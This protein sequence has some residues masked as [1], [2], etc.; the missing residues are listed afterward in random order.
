MNGPR[1]QPNVRTNA[2]GVKIFKPVAISISRPRRPRW[3]ATGAW[4]WHKPTAAR[5]AWRGNVPSPRGD[6]NVGRRAADGGVSCVDKLLRAPAR[7]LT[8]LIVGV[9]FVGN[10]PAGFVRWPRRK[11]P[12]RPPPKNLAPFRPLPRA[13]EI[14]LPQWLP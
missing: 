12:H 14:R 4:R 8:R 2:H 9:G 1:P 5:G 10:E 11:M 6:G 7:L 3:A 13:A